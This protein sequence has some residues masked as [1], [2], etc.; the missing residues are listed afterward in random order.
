MLKNAAADA[1]KG[2]DGIASWD[3]LRQLQLGTLTYLS[4]VTNGT[5]TG[6]PCSTGSPITMQFQM[7]VNFA[8]RT[9]GGGSSDI[10]ITGN[11]SASDN[12]NETA[13]GSGGNAVITLNGANHT[14]PA[15]NNTTFTFFNAGGETAKKVE[16]NLMF[17]GTLSETANNQ[18]A[19]ATR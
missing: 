11:A 14:N 5:C 4:P 15:F 9:Y 12:I 16:M 8:A 13:F 6:G 7:D 2:S 19:S 18:K 3:Q 10:T 1:A 17:V